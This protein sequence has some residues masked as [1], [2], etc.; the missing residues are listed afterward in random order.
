MSYVKGDP[1]HVQGLLNRLTYVKEQSRGACSKCGYSGHL[2]F[3]CRNFLRQNPSQ[4]VHL[5]VSST[6]SEEEEEKEEIGR[7]AGTPPQKK[8]LRRERR[9]SSDS[10]SHSRSRNRDRGRRD[11]EDS[12]RDREDSRRDKEDSRRGSRRKAGIIKKAREVGGQTAV[13]ERGLDPGPQRRREGT[14]NTKEI[15]ATQ[16]T[17]ARMS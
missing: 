4:E 17:A 14:R 3:E 1:T 12:R 7:A 10:D 9:R 8:G 11:R 16:V 5:D 2:T 15:M 13:V 6:S